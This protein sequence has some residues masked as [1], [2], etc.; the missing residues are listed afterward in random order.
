MPCLPSRAC[1]RLLPPA[2]ESPGRPGTAR[3]RW[4]AGCLTLCA[5]GLFHA[6]APAHAGD[7]AVDCGALLPPALVE[8]TAAHA[9]PQV[10]FRHG[11]GEIRRQLG[12]GSQAVALGMTTTSTTFSL[13]ISLSAVLR[14][15]QPGMC[16][17]PRM[18]LTLR[19]SQIEVW[20]ASEIEH[21][22][23]VADVVLKHELGHVA[24]ERQT[25]ITAAESMRSLLR[26]YYGERVYTGTEDAIKAELAAEFEHKWA[27][28]L[29]ALLKAGNDRHTA[30]DEADRAYD[31]QTCGGGLMRVARRLQ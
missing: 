15:D 14:R 4:L 5:T 8:V 2:E 11:A 31:A 10:N 6:T 29:S 25:L 23:C 1:R 26:A 20:L 28:E 19:H 12:S 21:D 27:A 7:Q 13:D 9:I 3:R 16:A 30:H 17:R 18:E 24:I 22:E